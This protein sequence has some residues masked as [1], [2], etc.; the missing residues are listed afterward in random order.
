MPAFPHFRQLD[1]MDCGP[2][3]LRIIAK[4]YGRHYSLQNL[5]DQS[6][7]TKEG[8]SLL[9]I[10]DAAENIGFHTTGVQLTFDQLQHEITLPCIAF[11]NQN[12]FVVVYKVK[13]DKVYVSDPATDK[14]VFTKEE[15]IKHWAS[16]GTEDYPEG[17]CL[18][19]EP[20]PAFYQQ[21]GD[22]VNKKSFGFLLSYLKP[23][24]KFMVQLVISLL[25]GSVLQLFFPFLTQAIVDKGIVLKDLTFIQIVLV[26]QLFLFGSR[27]MVDII[28]G[29]IVLH[30]GTRIN[31]SLISD[32]LQ[33]IMKLPISFFDKKLMG[34]IIQRID[35]HKRIEQ[36][37]SVSTLNVF[38]GLFNIIIFGIILAIY[39]LKIFLLYLSGSILYIA[40]VYLFLKRRRALDNKKFSE[41]SMNRSNIIQLINGMPEIKLN[42]CETQKR[43]E[44]E[45]IQ[46]R[47]FNINVKSLSLS[48]YQESGASF[49][50]EVKN[51]I[52]TVVAATLVIEGSLTLGMMLAISYILGQLNAPLEMLI[53]FLNQ[54]QDA[55]ISLERMAE[56]H[57][58]EN[59]IRDDEQ[60]F[61]ELPEHKTITI[62]GLHFQYEGPRSPYVLNDINLTIDEGKV[63]A[64][65]GTSGSGKTTLLKLLLGFYP[66]VE[67]ELLVGT[68]NLKYF[69]S[70]SW[71]KQCGV[72]MQDGFI[73]SDSI[74][75]NIAVSDEKTDKDKLLYAGKIANIMEFVENLPMGFNTKIGDEGHGLSQ[76]QK[77]RILIARAVYKNPAFIFFDE[78]TNA[79]DA[80][81]EKMIMENLDQFFRGK[82]VVVVA[83]RLSTVKNADKIV[84]LNKG[85]IIE[86]G[87]HEEL[88]AKKGEY[89]QLV[90]NQ[91]ELGA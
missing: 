38:F 79:L 35:D 73:F 64:I 17:I 39:S 60:F 47:L 27:L 14:I 45:R 52:I 1:A 37:L 85:E 19:L 61:T 82:T 25:L 63:T 12:H 24:R 69:N 78:A 74:A 5:R 55:K 66:P 18:L 26:A 54:S 8:V 49:F 7:I 58:K 86:L 68:Q 9:G 65:V 20:T 34:D 41:L 53:D 75:K 6:S 56:I 70:N 90:K 62:K 11:W 16:T 40:W 32:F 36:F 57:E 31:I 33:K 87:T 88:T 84:V 91:L 72:V 15:F 67:G 22:T 77:Q 71:R 42:N 23:Y 76:G 50:N 30:L 21:K 44:W 3:C 13:N 29:W 2:T 43:W 80:G 59:E 51:I 46:A 83:H 89:Y 48:Q 28:R 81:N 4:Y 10:S